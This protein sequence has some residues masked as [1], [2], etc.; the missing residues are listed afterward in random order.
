VKFRAASSA[1]TTNIAYTAA[2]SVDAD[3]TSR[4]IRGTRPLLAR[5]L[6]Q[7][8]NACP[9]MI[10]STIRTGAPETPSTLKGA[11]GDA[12]SRPHE[13][14][15]LKP[16]VSDMTAIP[17]MNAPTMSM[18]MASLP[19][20]ERSVKL[21]RNTTT[22]TTIRMANTGRQP[23]RVPSAPPIRNADSP[24]KALA[25]PSDPIAVACWASR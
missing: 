10:P 15:L 3:T 13:F 11:V 17:M 25:D 8:K 24:E 9:R 12:V 4:L 19:R 7:T 14:R 5:R 23:T 22:A 16:S 18:L 2:R 1:T 6:V 20:S 21:S